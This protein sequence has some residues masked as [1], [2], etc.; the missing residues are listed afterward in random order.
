[1][2]CNRPSIRKALA[3]DYAGDDPES[4][5]H[6]ESSAKRSLLSMERD[7]Q[8]LNAQLLQLEADLAVRQKEDLPT[9]LTGEDIQ[10]LVSKACSADG[11]FGSH[12]IAKS[13]DCGW[14]EAVEDF[15]Q[16]E[17]QHQATQAAFQRQAEAV[18]QGD[19]QVNRGQFL[20][21]CGGMLSQ[22]GGSF[23]EETC[24]NFADVAVRLSRATAGTRNLHGKS[25]DELLHAT[26]QRRAALNQAQSDYDECLSAIATLDGVANQFSR[27]SA[28]LAEQKDS[29]LETKRKV[30][31]EA[32]NLKQVLKLIAQATLAR[33]KI[34]RLLAAAFEEGPEHG[35]SAAREDVFNYWDMHVNNLAKALKKQVELVRDTERRLNAANKASTG[36]SDFK[37]KLSA[38]LVGLER[39]YDQA[40]RRPLR[41]IGL[42]ESLDVNIDS[43]VNRAGTCGTAGEKSEECDGL[44][45]WQGGE[46]GGAGATATAAAVAAV[47]AGSPAAA[48]EEAGAATKEG[49]PS[50]RSNAAAPAKGR[51]YRK[52]LDVHQ[53]KK[54]LDLQKRIAADRASSE[55]DG[56]WKALSLFGG[57]TLANFL[58]GGG[59]SSS[60]EGKLKKGQ[61]TSTHAS[62]MSE[63]A[64][65]LKGASESAA[66]T[67]KMT[68]VHAK[69]VD[70][71][72]NISVNFLS[73]VLDKLEHA[74]SG[75]SGEF[76]SEAGL[77]LKD[78]QAERDMLNRH[79]DALQKRLEDLS[80]LVGVNSLALEATHKEAMGSFME[81]LHAESDEEDAWD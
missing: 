58:G 29:Y 4:W 71:Q 61:K 44:Q 33:P 25:I 3:G 13:L 16:V 11:A 41:E 40:I 35:T 75:K 56:V 45:P 14:G 53:A 46:S 21:I 12:Q 62:F 27:L 15:E 60:S 77:G 28:A 24:E 59:R 48:Q 50:H 51:R 63:L 5:S 30:R 65:V 49:G 57:T 74:V 72:R 36:V 23:C 1:M 7:I 79:V 32:L 80:R 69:T 9:D 66:T 17:L 26:K 6:V 55:I 18:F 73:M 34:K 39:Y 31:M 76:A 42:R 8:Q 20:K 19:R 68:Q 64:G 67:W 38:A 2:I 22:L 37:G 52:I 54:K 78:L 43:L 81:L 47:A 10:D 70:V